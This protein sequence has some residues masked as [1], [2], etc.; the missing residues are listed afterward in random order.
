MAAQQLKIYNE[1]VTNMQLIGNGWDN[2]LNDE[3]QIE[4]F[5]KIV[6]LSIV[7]A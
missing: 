6:L 4:Y 2:I 7:Q 5:K 3:Y 1:E